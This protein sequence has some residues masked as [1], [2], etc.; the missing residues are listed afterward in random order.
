[1]AAGTIQVGDRV[2]YA[3]DLNVAATFGDPPSTVVV[4]TVLADE[5]T[6]KLSVPD[7]GMVLVSWSRSFAGWV[8]AEDLAVN[9][10]EEI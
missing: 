6:T 2:S 8:Y 7:A 1:M 4:G 10:H 5:R 9:D 3:E